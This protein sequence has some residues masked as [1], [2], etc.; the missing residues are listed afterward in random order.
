[1]NKHS[2]HILQAGFTL[3]EL[4]VSMAIGLLIVLALITLLINVNRNNSEMAKTNSQIENGRFAIQ[5]IQNDLV[6]AGFW[7]GFVPQFDDL[8]FETVPNDAPSATVPDPCLA[9]SAPWTAAYKKDIIGISLQAY[10]TTPPSGAG[11]VTNFA[12][13]KKVNT[14]VLVVRHAETCLPGVG[15]CEADT[16]G[17][18]YLQASLCELE[19]AT[20]YVLDTT[21]FTLHKRTCVGTGTP[22]ALPITST[23]FADKR[24]F[25]SNIYYIRDYAVTAGDGIP[26]LMRSQF[27]LA[28]GTLAHQAAEPLIEGIEGFSVEFGID[29]VS[30]SGGAVVPTAAI[31]WADPSAKT[32]PTN[33]GDGNPEYPFVQCTDAVPCTA[34][35]LANVV[36]VKLHVLVRAREVSPGYTDTKTYT[37]GATTLGPFNDRFKRHAFATTVRLTNVAGRRETP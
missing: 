10:G 9:Y 23:D 36:A 37:L 5:L 33:R 17:K 19:N 13:N 11:C 12:T 35:Q 29:S 22:P 31:V 21:G 3:V 24:K 8:T 27:D 2:R 26:T 15:N 28:A 34:A 30:D 18:L 7:G 6:H 4:M 14:D 20:P 25:I 16:A 32:S 1:M